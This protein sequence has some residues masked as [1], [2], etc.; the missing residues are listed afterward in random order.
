[1]KTN[2][3][4]NKTRLKKSQSGT[5]SDVFSAVSWARQVVVVNRLENL[6]DK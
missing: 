1:V 3:A 4:K 2:G 5:I 6:G